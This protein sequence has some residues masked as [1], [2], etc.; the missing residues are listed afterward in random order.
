MQK[1]FQKIR[2]LEGRD[3]KK[4]LYSVFGNLI[5]ICIGNN[6]P[7]VF[8][9]LCLD[10]TLILAVRVGVKILKN[11]IFLYGHLIIK[12]RVKVLVSCQEI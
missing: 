10:L 12:K 9:T 3:L 5:G 11:I 2:T 1:Y 4:S 6:R 7:G 8:Y